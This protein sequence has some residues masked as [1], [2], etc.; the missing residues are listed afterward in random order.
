MII[1]WLCFLNFVIWYGMIVVW[2]VFVSCSSLKSILIWKS[3]RSN[4]DN[5][6]SKLSSFLFVYYCLQRNGLD[7]WKSYNSAFFTILGPILVLIFVKW[8][9]IRIVKVHSMLGICNE[10]LQETNSLN[11]AANFSIPVDLSISLWNW[12]LILSKIKLNILKCG[13]AFSIF[14]IRITFIVE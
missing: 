7:I 1:F 5:K 14:V 9:I 3:N 13:P 4:F 2:I 12:F 10:F 8:M 11:E 6:H